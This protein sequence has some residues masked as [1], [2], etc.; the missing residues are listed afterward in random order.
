MTVGGSLEVPASSETLAKGHA[1]NW[2]GIRPHVNFNRAPFEWLLWHQPYG[3]AAAV[4]KWD[5]GLVYRAPPRRRIAP[6]NL[7]VFVTVIIPER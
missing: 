5:S 6:D 2:R 4:H 1:T 7:A 3:I